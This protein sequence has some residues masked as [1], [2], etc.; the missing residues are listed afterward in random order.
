MVYT[1]QHLAE[2]DNSATPAITS[3]M[4]HLLTWHATLQHLAQEVHDDSGLGHLSCSVLADVLQLQQY[5]LQHIPDGQLTQLTSSHSY[6][7]VH[8]L[9]QVQEACMRKVASAL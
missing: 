1:G 3:A 4:P 5:G 6:A 9:G 8:L 7:V 2:G